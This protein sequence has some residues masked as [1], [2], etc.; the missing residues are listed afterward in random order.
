M[1]DLN[2]S[3]NVP[4]QENAKVNN[5]FIIRGVAINETVTG[6]NH[7]FLGEE[8]R[9]AAH[10]LKGVPLLIDHDNSVKSIK[11]RVLESTYDE[12]NRR[13]PF[14]ANVISKEMQEMIEQ[15]LINSVSV[16]ATVSSVEEEDGG[17][18]IPRGIQFKELSLVA[19]PADAGATFTYALS[20]AYNL[21]KPKVIDNETKI[22]ESPKELLTAS[23]QIIVEND[24]S[25]TNERRQKMEGEIKEN[26]TELE[27]QSKIEVMEKQ[28]SE[29]KAKERK[30]LDE[31]YAKACESKGVKALDVS[32]FD[33]SAV[34]MLIEQV[35]SIVVKVEEK[36]TE[37][38]VADVT[39]EVSKY[40]II[41]E[42]G[43]LKGGSFTLM[44]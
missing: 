27:L 18:L 26:K 3:F 5:K 16:G 43:S 24:N 21:N 17:V 8:L 7:K 15:G 33:E 23:P 39:E 22:T 40:N 4:I 19:V 34:K 20:E 29:Y 41:S 11:G 12:T 37:A 14:V 6:N 13:I 2:F 30:A 25:H 42:S 31:S 1:K 44:Y 10:T 35:N 9:A 36:V 38:K 28:L 32:K